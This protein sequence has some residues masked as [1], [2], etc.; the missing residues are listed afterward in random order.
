MTRAD[1]ASFSHPGLGRMGKFLTNQG[2]LVMI[3]QLE[4]TKGL[5]YDSGP[6]KR[7]KIDEK[8]GWLMG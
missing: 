7:I 8:K 3:V 5:K 6:S 1:N 2:T 4:I